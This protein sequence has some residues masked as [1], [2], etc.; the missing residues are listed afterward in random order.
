MIGPSLDIRRGSGVSDCE[1]TG[2]VGTQSLRISDGDGECVEGVSIPSR[3]AISSDIFLIWMVRVCLT[4]KLGY[5]SEPNKS[6]VCPC[7]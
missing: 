6:C 4:L 2:T 7:F 3:F 1:W 5:K